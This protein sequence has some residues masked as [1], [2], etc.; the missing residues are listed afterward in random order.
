M[1]FKQKM[2]AARKR[3]E[4]QP[5]VAAT[6]HSKPDMS[7]YEYCKSIVDL[8]IAKLKEREQYNDN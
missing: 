1:N 4:Q 5:A 3:L 8:A 6:K 2:T 7:D